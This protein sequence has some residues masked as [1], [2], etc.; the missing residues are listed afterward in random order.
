MGRYGRL[1]A[2]RRSFRANV[3]PEQGVDVSEET[4]NEVETPEVAKPETPEVAPKADVAA[5]AVTSGEPGTI[6]IEMFPFRVQHAEFLWETH[7]IYLPEIPSKGE[8]ITV[9]HDQYRILHIMGRPI[10]EPGNPAPIG[11][12]YTLI[13]VGPVVEEL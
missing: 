4:V 7:T 13:V 8:V 3:S 1:Y 5:A 2:R 12:V 10:F 6:T 9:L 11:L